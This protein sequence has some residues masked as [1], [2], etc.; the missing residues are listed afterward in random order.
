[1]A[2]EQPE[3]FS[4]EAYESVTRKNPLLKK[5]IDEMIARGIIRIDEPKNAP[6]TGH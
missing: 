4:H 6:A 2:A 3:V 5:A 1:M